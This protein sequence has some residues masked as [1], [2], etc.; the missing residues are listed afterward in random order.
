MGTVVSQGDP[1]PAA[2]M[3][4]SPWYDIE[5]NGD[6][7]DSN[8]STDALVQRGLVEVMADLFLGDGSPTDPLA[9]PLHADLTGVPPVL[10]HVGSGEALVDDARRFAAKAETSGVDVTVEVVPDVQHAFAYSAGRESE[11]DH[12]VERMGAWVR[13]TLG[14]S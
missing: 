6:S 3:P 5:L 13:P 4:I 11:A 1:L 8:A 7:L 9:S 2:I 14:L 10:I 12:A